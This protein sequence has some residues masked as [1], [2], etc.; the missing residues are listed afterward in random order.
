MHAG[1]GVHRGRNVNLVVLRPSQRTQCCLGTR[2]I[3]PHG[4]AREADWSPCS[5]VGI[6]ERWSGSAWSVR[7]TPGTIADDGSLS[8][9]GCSSATACIAIGLD[10]VRWN[11][12]RWSLQQTPVETDRLYDEL[13]GVACPSAKVCVAVGFSHDTTGD[14][15]AATLVERW[16]GS[17]W[18]AQDTSKVVRAPSNS[19]LSG[20]SCVTATACIAV[21]S[22]R[23]GDGISMTLTER[24]TGSRWLRDPSPSP[25]D[26]GELDS[27]L[28]PSITLCVAVGST[29]GRTL[30]EKWSGGKWTIEA[31]PTP[32]GVLT[33][34]G[35]T[36]GCIALN[37]VSCATTS[38][39]IAVGHF[40]TA[41]N[42]ETLGT[43]VEGWD[44]ST[45]TIQATP[46]VGSFGYLNG[47]SCISAVLCIAV[48][49][50]ASANGNDL[51]EQ[52][53]GSNWATQTLADLNAP[54]AISCSSAAACIASVTC[55]TPARRRS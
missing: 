31:S 26:G 12:S 30:V 4:N 8:T 20:V 9:V 17:G 51:A 2:R 23:N 45:W 42:I 13:D 47:I 15:P 43:L 35:Y 54:N 24:W 50:G 39:C 34:C 38:S 28:C 18:A 7:P 48:G 27:V 33:H 46:D 32:P 6:A 25:P 55:Q 3:R 21:G 10:T 14:D 1:W 19:T 44:G 53:N 5:T 29:P 37:A 49:Y 11:G 52:W 22:F 36:I 40:A 41:H 16:N